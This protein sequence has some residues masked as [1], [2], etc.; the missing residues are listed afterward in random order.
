[1]VAPTH[2]FTAR[3]IGDELEP[4]RQR[5]VE[6]DASPRARLIISGCED[7]PG[8]SGRAP[9][10]IRRQFSSEPRSSCPAEWRYAG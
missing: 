5:P 9:P 8:D 1:L 2:A 7:R 3:A 10:R 6:P 4:R